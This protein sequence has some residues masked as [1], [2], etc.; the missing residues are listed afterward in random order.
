MLRDV[1]FSPTCT[2]FVR[3]FV[4][5]IL[6]LH[7]CGAT[8][9]LRRERSANKTPIVF[10]ADSLSGFLSVMHAYRGCD[11]E[12]PERIKTQPHDD[13]DECFL[14]FDSQKGPAV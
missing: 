4:V 3:L 9:S 13:R 5:A 10:H 2:V 14:P 11:Y 6:P 7:R 12:W 1:V 8:Q